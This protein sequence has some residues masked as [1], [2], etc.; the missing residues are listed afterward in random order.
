MST[1]TCASGTLT[2]D[3]T[4]GQ[5]CIIPSTNGQCPDTT[6]TVYTSTQCKKAPTCTATPTASV[7]PTTTISTTADYCGD[8]YNNKGCACRQQVTPGA[9]ESANTA[10]IC[11]YQEEGIQY[12]CDPGCCP[13]GTCT[14]APTTSTSTDTTTSTTSTGPQDKTIFWVMVALCI[15]FA[16]AMFGGFAYASRK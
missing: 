9:G 6:W 10:L 2:T 12:A 16:L 13:G 3:T 5:I 4:L 15:L 14:A 7:L 11:A 8:Q 1:C